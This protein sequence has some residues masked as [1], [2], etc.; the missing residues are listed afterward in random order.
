MPIMNQPCAYCGTRDTSRTKGHVIPQSL[1]SLSLPYSVQWITVPECLNCKAVWEDV[2]PHFRNVMLAIWDPEKVIKDDRFYKMD[3][4]FYKLDGQRRLRELVGRF[5][6][7][8]TPKGEREMLFPDKDPACNLIFR[9]IV[10]GL[11]Y[12]HDLGSPVAD[13]RV[14]TG[15]M[16]WKLPDEFE[17]EI[18]WTVVA[19]DFF[20][21]GYS[22]INKAGVH[23]FWLMKFSKH[24]ELF[25]VVSSDEKGFSD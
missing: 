10:R 3:R 22:L 14:I 24:I 13:K 23:S 16:I 8:V 9:R 2:E 17:Q 6:P 4:S 7:V 15:T 25:G 11:C 19:P 1:Y 12:I 18:T 20:R 21:Y 5:V